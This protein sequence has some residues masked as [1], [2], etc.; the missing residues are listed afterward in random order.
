[1]DQA[2]VTFDVGATIAQIS[3]D[4]NHNSGRIEVRLVAD[5]NY[6]LGSPSQLATP[7][8]ATNALP[9]LT[10]SAAGSDRISE[11]GELKFVVRAAPVPAV[12][13]TAIVHV[14]Q[15]GDFISE[16][17]ENDIL[18][19]SVTIPITGENAGS[20]EFTVGLDDDSRVENDGSITATI[21]DGSGYVLGDYTKIAT[22]TIADD[23]VPLPVINWVSNSH[24]ITEGTD[25]AT[26][27]LQSITVQ[28]DNSVT[29]TSQITVDYTLTGVSYASVPV[30]IKLASNAPGRI[31][32]ST[33]TI[34]LA[35]GEGS[36]TIPLEVI[37]D[38]HDEG[39]EGFTLILS[40]PSGVIIGTPFTNV[41]IIDD[42]ALPTVS[43]AP[44]VAVTETDTDFTSRIAVQ[45]S[46][47][48]GREISVG[49]VVSA[50]S[51]T[52]GEDFVLTN[53]VVRFTPDATTTITELSKDINFTIKGDELEENTEQFRVIFGTIANASTVG[54]NT[55]G[56]VTIT[57]D[58][59]PSVPR[60]T[61]SA[62]S[63]VD[64][65]SGNK[66]IFT[67][68]SDHNL[69]TD[70]KFRYQLS[71]TG[72]VLS[73]GRTLDTSIL[74][75]EDFILSDRKY[76]TTIELA[77]DDDNTKEHTG[78]VTLTLLAK[79]ADTG[80][81][82][83]SETSSATILVY[84][85]EV[86][87]LS[88]AG[89]GIITERPNAKAQFDVTA[90]FNIAGAIL[91]RYQPDDGVSDFLTGT[92]AGN[93]QIGRLNFNGTKSASFKV[94][95]YD[96]NVAE[97][98]GI[99]TAELLNETGGIFNYT[100]AP[101]PA[102]IGS[103][104]VNDND[105]L[106]S[107]E[108]QSVTLETEPTP[109]FSQIGIANVDYYVGV[110]NTVT[111]DL[112]VVYEYI[113]GLTS[114]QQSGG[115]TTPGFDPNTAS[116]WTRG[117]VTIL[118]GDTTG[119][120]TIPVQTFFG[121]NIT[122]RLVDGAN[123]D[124]GTPS[125]Q[126]IA[127]QTATDTNPLVSIDVVGDR[128]IL[129]K[130]DVVYLRDQAGKLI[131]DSRTGAIMVDTS[132]TKFKTKFVVSATPS[133]KAGSSV[134]VDVNFTQAN[135]NIVGE[136]SNTFTRTVTLTNQQTSAEIEFELEVNT[137][138][139]GDG[140]ISAVVPDGTGYQVG[141]YSKTAS[142]RIIDDES[143]PV[144]TINNPTAVSESAGSVTFKVTSN[145]QP[146]GDSL[147]VQYGLREPSGDF[148][149]TNAIVYADS[150]RLNFT[151]V[152]GSP[153]DYEADLVIELENDEEAESNG[154][155]SVT[156]VSD[157]DFTYR[158][159]TGTNDVG[160]VQIMD[161]DIPVINWVSRSNVITEGTDSATPTLQSITV[162]LDNSVTA[163]SQIT[164]DYTLTGVSYAS[165]PVD[166]KLASNAPGRIS[167][168]TGT[169]TLAAG[170]GSATI[171]LEV[172][173]DSHDEG[174]EGF[175]LILSNPSGV[176]IGTPFTNVTIID[177]DAL[178]TVSIA[179][180]V[181]VTE[182]DTDFTSRIAVQLS[183]ASGREISV[184][185]VV[186]ADSAT[187]GEDFVLTNGVVRFTPDATT[188]ITE[189]SKDI[190][191]TIKGDELEEST[192]QFRVIFGAIANAS[193]VGQNTTGTVTITDDDAPPVIPTISF[194]DRDLHI[195]EGSGTI[196][197]P[198]TL[199]GIATNYPVQLDWSIVPGT[200]TTS[201]YSIA[202]GNQ[203]P[204]VI[205]SGTT[206]SVV[207]NITNDDLIEGNETF[208]V[209]FDRNTI[210]NATIEGPHRV[211][212]TIW[213]DE[214]LQTFSISAV[215]AQSESYGVQYR[216]EAA[217]APTVDTPLTINVAQ[218]GD[219]IKTPAA[220]SS[221]LGLGTNNVVF[222]ANQRVENFVVDTKA[223]GTATADGSITA[224]LQSSFTNNVDADAGSATVAIWDVDLPRATIEP[225]TTLGVEEGNPA[226]FKVSVAPFPTTNTF[227][228]NVDVSQIVYEGA[229][230]IDT[231][232]STDGVIGMRTVSL[233]RK[234]RQDPDGNAQTYEYSVEFDVATDED[235]DDENNGQIVASIVASSNYNINPLPNYASA[236]VSV[237]DND[238]TRTQSD[239]PMISIAPTST[240]P[241]AE[242]GLVTFELKA[243]DELSVAK[244][245][246]TAY[247]IDIGL[248]NSGGNFLD[249]TA[250]GIT[251][252]PITFATVDADGNSV[253]RTI[254]QTTT[255]VEM[256]AN[257]TSVRFS[258]QTKQDDVDE[259]DG[260]IIAKVITGDSSSYRLIGH[261]R[262]VANLPVF[263]PLANALS[264]V[265]IA[266][267]L[268][269]DAVPE[270]SIMADSS[271]II[272][273]ADA[274]FTISA[275]RETYKDI[276][277]PV[278]VSDGDGNFLSAGTFSDVAIP[279]GSQSATYLVGTHD[280]QV[281]EADGTISVTLDPEIVFPV[282]YTV[283]S[284][285]HTAMVDVTD[286]DGGVPVPVIS[287]S[288]VESTIVEGD[289]AKFDLVSSVTQS[290][291]I[292]VELL[293]SGDT[294]FISG[295]EPK[296][297]IIPAGESGVELD[298]A[299]DD[300]NT[301][302]SNGTITITIDNG[303]GYDSATGNGASASVT[304]VDNDGTNVLPIISIAADSSA[305]ITEGGSA[306][307]TITSDQSITAT[308]GL[309]INLSVTQG[310]SNFIDG[311]P[312]TSVNIPQN[313]TTA[314]LQV[315]T[316]QDEV[317]EDD[318]RIFV[319]VLSD[320]I[321]GGID[322]IVDSGDN[323]AAVTIWDDEGTAPLAVG[324]YGNQTV[325]EGF[326]IIYTV[327]TENGVRVP[328][329]QNLRVIIQITQEGDFIEG[330]YG[331]HEVNIPNG[332]SSGQLVIKTHDDIIQET[333]GRVTGTILFG[334]GYRILDRF[335]TRVV[336]VQDA[337]GDTATGIPI[338]SVAP[339]PDSRTSVSEAD[340]AEF[341]ITASTAPSAKLTVGISTSDG[342]G[343][344]LA[345]NQ[346]VTIEFPDGETTYTH[347]VVL[348][349][350]SLDEQDGEVTLTILDHT[351]PSAATY[352]IATPPANQASVTITDNDETPILS[353]EAVN[354]IVA[355]SQ[356][357]EL[358]FTA[359]S[360]LSDQATKVKLSLSGDVNEYVDGDALFNQFKAIYIAEELGG[361]ESSYVEAT[362]D[363]LVVANGLFVEFAA[364]ATTATLTIPVSDDNV[365][366]ADGRVT[367][368]ILTTD[369]YE[370]DNGFDS[371]SVLVRDNDIPTLTIAGGSAVTEGAN[372]TFTV[373]MSP[374]PSSPFRVRVLL[375][376]TGDFVA[377][378]P[379]DQT[380]YV[381]VVEIG[382]DGTGTL[383]VAT[384]D[385]AQ[386]ENNGEVS[387]NVYRDTRTPPRYQLGNPS[388]VS[389]AVNDNDPDLT[390]VG[391]A[392]K[393]GQAS[394]IT[395]GGSIEIELTANPTP[396]A[397]SPLAI[398]L[399]VE[400]TGLGTGYLNYTASPI[401]ITDTT[402]PLA[403]TINTHGD[404]LDEDHGEI[405]IRL[406]D[407]ADY[408]ASASP[409][410][411]VVVT[412]QDDEA[413]VP[414]VSI[415][416][417]TESIVEGDA[418]PFTVT[419]AAGT[420]NW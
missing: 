168:S 291:L 63:N 9:L 57:D 40:N 249:T 56:T 158:V 416:T 73:D 215:D 166:I 245:L 243:T 3:H 300:D 103:V 162:Q 312:V 33:G 386:D 282:S 419:M 235:D 277:I 21:Q 65:G 384:I 197:I 92:T 198:I 265:A 394:T 12:T 191:F 365:V 339:A 149:V 234:T 8:A 97:E 11:A 153:T 329:R 237:R 69:G 171:P 84:D 309:D 213:D 351:D 388:S 248:S 178:P 78:T 202:A 46:T 409:L 172:I 357:I 238:G 194:A 345:A 398:T 317:E 76:V 208:Q 80:D 144:L 175:T 128:R 239:L 102:N 326:D 393:A 348:D 269:N 39:T 68:S 165:V 4:A 106:P 406:E 212:V 93:P 14:T 143:L 280:D 343:D 390:R 13:K 218:V 353:V 417:T 96:D 170:E 62:G 246:A 354:P 89:F 255:R 51:A 36:A 325:A 176:I 322:Y 410:N 25:S 396:T 104:I 257:Q 79:A 54:Q 161:D 270:I 307:F 61:V 138:A 184:G 275:N 67:I 2:S 363:P 129:E 154:S 236:I 60:L 346:P 48:S 242:G 264:S 305:A 402:N 94:P 174:T 342:T 273:G 371:V 392:L 64:E 290:T 5:N 147:R 109:S 341:V 228:V 22:V 227:D 415:T 160:V 132:H 108:I 131:R 134:S 369:E 306:N 256:P 24:V 209:R 281:G 299:T 382:T 49:Y 230:F 283:S 328:E 52:A 335:R 199:S 330:S 59:T 401:Q 17:L 332:Q 276:L 378:D 377:I 412:V 183:T 124:L 355:E 152:A 225:I 263:N 361:N 10:I 278:T 167:D 293:V 231:S 337:G 38:S 28:L 150:Q 112:E 303:I 359:T 105:A 285:D 118:A 127:P 400:E 287:I 259:P 274:Q 340:K 414:A 331:L 349:D 413:D 308:S 418:I 220:G 295:D 117:T 375:S 350:D 367:I 31:S 368:R 169:I 139:D 122:V 261:E 203:S 302:E 116:N 221:A 271:S 233:T 43:I 19:K 336:T 211:S 88:I 186:S 120:F 379:D 180:A 298:V 288:S 268:D 207:I 408:L 284:R 70:F 85:D 163:T 334:E 32:D 374:A 327:Q 315:S 126:N 376:Q 7:P 314:P 71:Q 313:S 316:A 296:S 214:S 157:T 130:P 75:T 86:P 141:D 373:T 193:T 185:Y 323:S 15:T 324:L 403:L 292:E 219:F 240:T 391:V 320:E 81:Y 407:T 114:S 338:L 20:A 34:T 286:N 252:T 223:A 145:S 352:A 82:T 196:T 200:A 195:G 370:L 222:G 30:D 37:A 136:S 244:T 301:E 47:A 204:L 146:T 362:H 29:A 58:D 262:G 383:E 344:F 140:T 95:I 272:E 135:V 137:S 45:L 173:A 55:T 83:L 100:V 321:T 267:V 50:D 119:Q 250:S 156:L 201:D 155:I 210:Q 107:G 189:L 77:I 125:Q 187:A 304:V 41:T 411:Q 206:G 217:E 387:A 224:T 381:K 289:T 399:V 151:P 101:A 405:T 26:P 42:D 181:A 177:D 366:E 99:V 310:D 142:V 159:V 318:G 23:D 229:S 294:S 110:P 260:G 241:V 311:I 226:R 356:S 1:M 133:P 164:V 253:N 333:P 232:D 364:N 385:D 27:T 380:T 254:T 113:Y 188:T 190:N 205:N 74:A 397:G 192:E 72:N 66:A 121:T 53:G 216:V 90:Q 182:T 395:E 179:P 358:R 347:A 372:A 123:Y 18:V 404:D 420:S 6:D 35:A 98:N 251:S 297:V 389:V 148:L 247:N 16:T 279:A 115:G 87:A 360:A 91:F 111:K 258:I 44:A 319:R 266:Q